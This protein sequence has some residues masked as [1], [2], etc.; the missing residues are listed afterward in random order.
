MQY[1]AWFWRI[2]LCGSLLAIHVLLLTSECLIDPKVSTSCKH[3]I[4]ILCYSV[5]IS[6]VFLI[7]H[8]TFKIIYYFSHIINGNR[9]GIRNQKRLLTPLDIIFYHTAVLMKYC[10]YVLYS[11]TPNVDF[12]F[13]PQI[14]WIISIFKSP[15]VLMELDLLVQVLSWEIKKLLHICKL[16]INCGI[17]QH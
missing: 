4:S 11:F 3:A 7:H 5:S 9:S 12:A 17:W 1:L 14:I 8:A 15:L 6:Q 2:L 16:L 10:I 13:D